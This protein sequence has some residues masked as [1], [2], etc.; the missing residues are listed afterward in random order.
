MAESQTIKIIIKNNDN[1][2]HVA[3]SR[4]R[5]TGDMPKRK[6]NRSGRRRRRR[7]GGGE[8]KKRRRRVY[9]AGAWAEE[10]LHKST[11][12]SHSYQK[13]PVQ[14]QKQTYLIPK[15]TYENQIPKETYLILKETYEKTAAART[16][17]LGQRVFRRSLLAEEHRVPR[18][19]WARCNLCQERVSQ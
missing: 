5:C 1:D 3:E 6:C 15:V 11:F 13:C 19:S 4:G 2:I 12:V 7:G 16:R 14:R 9:G 17:K 10:C 18:S 8:E